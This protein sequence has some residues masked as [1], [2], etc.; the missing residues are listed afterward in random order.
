MIFQ[1]DKHKLYSLFGVDDFDSIESNIYTMAPSMVEYYLNDL[2]SLSE[3]SYEYLNRSFI[4]RSIPLDQYTLFLDYND[5]TFL[6]ITQNQEEQ[7]ET[8]SLW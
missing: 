7:Y 4:Q 8:L 1:L 6:E 3:N 5:E 2:A